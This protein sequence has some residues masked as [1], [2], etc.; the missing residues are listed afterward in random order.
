MIEHIEHIAVAS[1]TEAESDKFFV[2]LLSFKKIRSFEVDSAKMTKFFGVNQKKN[3]VRYQ[4]DNV[5]VEVII[6]GDNTKAK[7]IFTHTCLVVED[8]DKLVNK[9]NSLGFTIIKVPRDDGNG[10]YLFLKD[11]YENLYEIK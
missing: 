2:D 7:D 8:Q 3:F 5:G 9:A 6:T 1:A 4:K 10:F 11:S